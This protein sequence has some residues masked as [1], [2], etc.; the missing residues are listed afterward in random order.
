MDNVKSSVN[1]KIDADIKERA[2]QLLERM[3]M[4]QTTAI[5]LFFRQIIAEKRFPFQPSPVQTYGEQV[6]E[7]IKRRNIPNITLPADENGN[8]YIDKDLH[9]ELYDWAVN[10]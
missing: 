5:D 3:G 7:L 6:L 8:A 1:V 4:D 9:P 10:G 2:T